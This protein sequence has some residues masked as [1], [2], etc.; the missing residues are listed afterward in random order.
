MKNLLLLSLITVTF[1]IKAQTSVYHPF[2]D[3]N[4]VWNF[5]FQWYC[6]ANGTADEYYSITFSGDTTISSQTYHKL[7]TPFVR[8][9]STGICGGSLIGY[10]GAIRQDTVARKI[11]FVPPSDSAEQLLYDFNMQVGDTIQGYL[12]YFGLPA[13]I[14]SI[15]SILIGNS[16]RKRWNLSC[17][18]IQVI[19]GIGNT[20]G[21]IEY[22]P[23][24]ATDFPD[25]TLTCFSQNEETLYPDMTSNCELITSVKSISGRGIVATLSPN[26][27]NSTATFTVN[28]HLGN[29]ELKIY[30]AL[31]K[32]VRQQRINSLSTTIHRDRL[33]NGIYFYQVTSD[34]KQVVSGKFAIE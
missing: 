8:S 5:H 14:Q 9:F 17:Y 34:N 21:L 11:F 2:P 20:Y 33:S 28:I 6:F 31:G 13:I 29:T 7:N 1:S 26:P 3:S 23:G 32:Q 30:N 15:D 27:F 19:E 12:D 16:F 10:K 18:G 22:L 25:Y 24:C 4:A